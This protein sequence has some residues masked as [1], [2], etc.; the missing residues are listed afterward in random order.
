[1]RLSLSLSTHTHTLS[2]CVDTSTHTYILVLSLIFRPALYNVVCDAAHED[3]DAPPARH[4]GGYGR[5]LGIRG[6][7]S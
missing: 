6:G 3:D 4:G 2:P 1:M 5:L 7:R